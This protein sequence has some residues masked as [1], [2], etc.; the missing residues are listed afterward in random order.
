VSFSGM[1]TCRIFYFR[2]GVLE[3][4][5]ELASE[6]VVEAAKRASSSHPDLT[7][8]IWVKGRKA[9]IVRPSWDHRHKH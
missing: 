3:D 6:N 9:A 5:T 4:A 8:E 7:A 1:P 2:G